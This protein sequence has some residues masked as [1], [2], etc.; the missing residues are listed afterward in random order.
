[1]P[2]VAARQ[3]FSSRGR[4]GLQTAVPALQPRPKLKN[5]A[6]AASLVACARFVPRLEA[7]I[8]AA[9]PVVPD[10]IRWHSS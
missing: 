6:L 1:M 7:G 10:G 3:I 8:P 2:Q 5:S 4:A 9:R